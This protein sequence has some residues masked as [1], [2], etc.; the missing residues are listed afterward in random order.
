M[1]L[2]Q[3]LIIVIF[4]VYS[5]LTEMVCGQSTSGTLVGFVFDP[6]GATVPNA[7]VSVTSEASGVVISTVTT[8]TGQY[9]IP[10][11][12]VGAYTVKV[13]AP[14]FKEA[15]IT[16]IMVPL[17]QTVTVN[18]NLQVGTTVTTTV[19]VNE[20]N[21]VIDTTTS[22]IQ[23]TF[24]SRQMEELPTVS[25]GSGVINLSL[26][27]AGVASNG[28]VGVGAGPSI[29]GQRPRNN[30]FTI[31]GID[32][33]EKATTGPLVQVPND[34]VAEFSLLQNNFSPQFGHSSGGQF[35]Q[36]VKSG[37]NQFH[38]TL[39]EYFQNRNL[40]ASDQFAINSAEPAH[41]RYDNNRFG[42]NFG[43]PVRRNKLFFFLDYEYN[44]VGQVGT[45][46]A[47]YAPTQA[48]YNVL[49]SLPGVNQTNLSVLKQYLAAAI[50]PISPSQTV[51]GKYPIVAG[52]S[53]PLG[54]VSIPAPNYTNTASG[55]ASV[56]YTISEQDSLRGRFLSERQG[57]I[58]PYAQLSSFSGTI[59]DNT[60]IATLTE[61]HNF[62]P[63]LV[64]EFR[65][66]YTRFNQTY[67][68][69]HQVFPGLDA[70]PNI[71]IDELG[72][73][74]GPDPSAPQYTVQNTYQ[75][76]DNLSWL[77]GT[78]QL[79]FGVNVLKFITPSFF[80]QR[81][82]GDY[83]WTTLA[84]YL[85]DAD[86]AFAERSL[87]GRTYYGD[88]V[89]FGTYANDDWKIHRNLTLNL[90][91]RYDRTTIPYS[92]RLQSVNELASVPGV[93]SFRS[94]KAQNLNLQPRIGFA[95]SPG[96]AGNTS[97]RGGFGI[98]YDQLFDN[99]GTLSL[100]PQFTQT[101]TFNG[102]TGTG[103][104]ANGGI[105]QSAYTPITD[106]VTARAETTAFIPDQRLPKSLQWTLGIQRVFAQNYTF[107]SRYL[108]DRGLNLPMQ[109]YINVQS[110]VNARN[111]LPVFF[112]P[113]SQS[114]LNGLTSTLDSPNGLY[115]LN[116]IVPAYYNAGFT[117]Y[118]N[119][120]MPRGNSTYH[121]WANQ[122]TR[123][124]NNGLQ[125]IG[126]YTW[127]HNIDDS[128]AE[129]HSTD[130]TARRPQDFQ[131]LREERA[132]S[133]LD[134]RQRLTFAML[135]ELP[136]FRHSNWLVRNLVGNWEV[137]PIYTYQTGTLVTPFSGNID[138]NLNG[139]PAG[140]RVLV[141][142]AGNP[143]LGSA[144]RPL[145]NSA[146]YTVGYLVENPRAGYIQGQPG[147]RVNGG[148][149][150]EHLPPIDDVDLT[151][152]KRINLTEQCAVEFSARIFNLLNH[153]Q[154]VAGYINDVQ[155]FSYATGPAVD[156]YLNPSTSS[157]LRPDQA[158][159][160]NPRS[161]QL[162]LKLSF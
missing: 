7:S 119:A 141:N 130:T 150:L 110:P 58:D 56:D 28:A 93:L 71:T 120:F 66:G 75:G 153:P 142:P 99:L 97:I 162:A 111:A 98:N 139:D 3:A 109:E 145:T 68:I 83:E 78:H 117:N 94:P 160:S 125:F 72:V 149:N 36:V 154:Y 60:Y 8:S 30:N 55:V 118:I 64:N 31:E 85:T 57:A 136:L 35:N 20:S 23:T 104:L 45:T 132:S 17:N 21:A 107:E 76:T 74:V 49:A 2:R 63:R 43:G 1:R 89:Q 47:I 152:Q 91:L 86:P 15:E 5:G 122:L 29:G 156:N 103:F 22:Q 159:S 113:P 147:V 62:T 95:Y 96:T 129:L 18:V 106:P 161:I 34:A 82:R 41:P 67:P 100:P 138:A 54:Q 115:S 81:V 33:N 69:G 158:F 112:S 84:T 88:Q 77:R 146:G 90:G 114:K 51:Y 53:I 151:I 73:N 44:P 9:S 16:K 155:P 87:G 12:L 140:D 123:R 37:T 137:A 126:A 105:P 4:L 108:G 19:E 131:N 50:S 61:F 48:G 143:A 24:Q 11:L 133:A 52:Q 70:F 79:S 38:G 148:R 40:D 135:Y 116:T 134:H 6:T 128:T 80:T 39:Y 25:Q 10:N 124:F 144:L 26:L 46:G 92:E 157:F 14:G 101:V 27:T 65:L 121:G 59:T 42:G 127:S 32:N 102:Q 13:S